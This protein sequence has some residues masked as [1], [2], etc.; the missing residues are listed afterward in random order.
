V[1]NKFLLLLLRHI[2]HVGY[3]KKTVCSQTTA[4]V[5]VHTGERGWNIRNMKKD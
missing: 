3:A 5:F 1:A 2:N 4:I